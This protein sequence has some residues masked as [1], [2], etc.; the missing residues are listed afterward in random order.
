[1]KQDYSKSVSMQCSTCGE[2]SFEFEDENTPVRCVSCDRV[3]T[4]EELIREN[5]AQVDS[6]VEGMKSEIVADI[7]KDLKKMF[8]KFK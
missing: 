4:R 3:F 6:E 1:M 7:R 2:T 8:K 5:G